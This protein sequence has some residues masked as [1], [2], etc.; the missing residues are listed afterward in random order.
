LSRPSYLNTAQNVNLEHR[1]ADMGARIAAF[2]IDYVIKFGYIMFIVVLAGASGMNSNPWL[3]S[4]FFLPV[5]LYTLLFEVFSE[6]QTPGKKSQSIQVVSKDGAP[7]K[8]SQYLL[9]W[10][11]NIIDFYILSGVVALI[12]IGATRSNQRLGDIIANTLVISNKQKN[13][14]EDTA[15]N[16]IDANYVPSY[17]SAINLTDEDIRIIK[18]VLSN[19]S[20]NAFSLTTETANKIEE[21]L[22]VQKTGSSRIFL[23]MV[24]KDYNYYQQVG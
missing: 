6:G 16:A 23:K 2:L 12:S 5:M 14:L 13:T 11:F 21:I 24:I 3:L 10:L 15:Y 22:V 18:E 1:L 9:R 4:L 20:E 19:E 17:P 8:I 7:V